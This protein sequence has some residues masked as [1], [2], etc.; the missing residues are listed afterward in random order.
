M[1]KGRA[2]EILNRIGDRRLFAIF[3]NN[4][5]GEFNDE[6]LYT[7]IAKITLEKLGIKHNAKFLLENH[8]GQSTEERMKFIDENVEKIRTFNNK[9]ILRENE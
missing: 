8:K 6:I 9:S 3:L 7:D 4:G 5:K 1:M 2:S